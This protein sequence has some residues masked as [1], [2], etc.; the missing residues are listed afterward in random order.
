MFGGGE[1]KRWTFFLIRVT[2]G[3]K[4]L[5][6]DNKKQAVREEKPTKD[7]CKDFY[8]VVSIIPQQMRTFKKKKK[9][10]VT[11]L[12]R[13]SQARAKRASDF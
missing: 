11:V 3:L 1:E 4:L 2:Q 5:R 13:I 10:Y 9:S 6:N 7:D 8:F 12:N